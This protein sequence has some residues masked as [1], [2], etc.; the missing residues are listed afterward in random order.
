[1]SGHSHKAILC[2]QAVPCNAVV[3][4]LCRGVGEV[5]VGVPHRKHAVRLAGEVNGSL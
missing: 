3:Q 1:M 5:Q 4:P 2:A